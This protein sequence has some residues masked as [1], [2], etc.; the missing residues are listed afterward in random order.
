MAVAG[1]GARAEIMDKVG[2]GAENKWFRL[3]NTVLQKCKNNCSFN[4][5]L[6]ETLTQERH[7]IVSAEVDFDWN[8]TLDRPPRG[9]ESPCSADLLPPLSPRTS[10]LKRWHPRRGR[11]SPWP[12]RPNLD[13]SPSLLCG[14]QQRL[15]QHHLVLLLMMGKLWGQ[16]TMTLMNH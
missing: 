4:S 9:P 8:L 7:T 15:Q 11:Y 6:A 5:F 10:L 3:R 12:R 1:A 13:D 16:M 2:A 14:Q